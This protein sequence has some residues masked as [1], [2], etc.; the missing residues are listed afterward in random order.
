M[1]QADARD[2]RELRQEVVAVEQE[3]IGTAEM[4]DT[5]KNKTQ[6]DMHLC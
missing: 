5:L 4:A 3:S 6:G 1:L 2:Y